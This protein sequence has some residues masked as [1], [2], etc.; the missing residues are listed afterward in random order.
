MIVMW[1][2]LGLGVLLLAAAVMHAVWP[3]ILDKEFGVQAGKAHAG[4]ESE[5]D[6]FHIDILARVETAP[7]FAGLEESA[8]K[9]PTD[10]WKR[11]SIRADETLVVK[12]PQ[13]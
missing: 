5:D 1:F 12:A 2:A 4:A 10:Q 9:G 11:P 8:A 7:R 13:A 6:R 3:S